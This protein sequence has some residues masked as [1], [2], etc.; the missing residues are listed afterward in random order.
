MIRKYINKTGKRVVKTCENCKKE[1]ETLEI[2]VRS[3]GEKYCSNYCYNEFRSNNKQDKKVLNT[4]H[5]I[6]FKY[7]LDKESYIKLK[8]MSDNKCNICK[9]E[10]ILCVDHCHET[11]KIR[12]LL[13]HD[14][15]LLLGKAKDDI[16]ILQNSIEYLKSSL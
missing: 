9:E 5:Q 1:F 8:E 16:T 7:G 12:G 6:K 10:K 15:N 14:C 2:K 4:Y 11:G 13:C 3:K